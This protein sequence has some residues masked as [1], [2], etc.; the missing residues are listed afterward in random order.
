MATRS[1]ERERL[2][3]IS[4]LSLDAGGPRAISQLEILKYIMD[5]LA[6]DTDNDGS[7][8]IKRP[9]EVFAMIGGTGTGGLIAILLAVL[10]MTANEALETF[11]DLANKVFKNADSDPIKQTEKL[12]KV[13]NDILAKHQ[14][15]VDTKL[16]PQNGPPP[17]CG[18]YVPVVDKK[19][20]GSPII[21]TNYV[22]RRE[23]PASFTIAEAMLTT[24]ASTPMFSPVKVVKDY[25]K[26]E[27]ISADLGLCNP[28][29]EI[30]EGAHSVFGDETIIIC[31]LSIGCGNLGVNI[32]PDRPHA[33]A[34]VTF[35]KRIALDGERKAQ[36]VASY[37]AK[38]ALYHRVSVAYG[39][40]I[41]EDESWRTAED[42]IAH[43]HTY[44]SD[45]EV[46]R[47]VNRCISTLKDGI[48]STTLEQLKYLGGGE[49][50]APE[51]L[52]LTPNYVERKI[53]TDFLENCLLDA[54]GGIK[55]GSKRVI[56]TG[57][58]GC[59][60]TQLV[61]KFIE[62]HSDLFVSVFFVDGSSKET[63]KRD[64]TEHVRALGG[65]N[66]Q[67]SFEESMKLLSLPVQG[68]ERLL[69]MDNVD[70]PNLNIAAFLPRWKRGAVIITSRNVSHGQL[71]PMGH[72]QLDVMSV[73][74]S[75]ELLV[76]GSGNIQLSGHH[77]E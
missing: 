19:N 9:C 33:S 31:A 76:R 68:G 40:E 63:L 70:D 11:I 38:L 56:V 46:A 35:L 52:E 71:S 30:I 28:I 44:L 69:V 25:S 13:I 1:A 22:D 41:S 60:K 26:A 21:L 73:D 54:D 7:Q 61:R 20:T 66:S 50:L 5:R 39:M 57:M 48:G 3:G 37:M 53:P 75:I 18:L 12:K 51:L 32:A 8:T 67:M 43:T 4:L 15:P 34:L 59:G 49:V 47:T 62:D 24:C 72:L 17:A 27:Y 65:E 45:E 36:D 64:I 16:V 23:L 77:R 2:A 42:I 29:R 6:K 74:E 58:G 14:V 10:K 55:G